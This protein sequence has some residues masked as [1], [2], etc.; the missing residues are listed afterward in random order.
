[1]QQLQVSLDP[2]QLEF[3]SKF[4]QYGFRNESDLVRAALRHLQ[5]EFEKRQL[6]QSAELYA[7]LYEEDEDLRELTEMDMAKWPE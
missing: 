5:Q 3:V 2:S 7:E 4:E 6:E 1:M